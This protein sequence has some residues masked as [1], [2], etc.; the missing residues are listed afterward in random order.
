MPWYSLHASGYSPFFPANRRPSSDLHSAASST[1]FDLHELPKYSGHKRTLQT[2]YAFAC[3]PTYHW[4]RQHV[5]YAL[6]D[7]WDVLQQRPPAYNVVKFEAKRKSAPNSRAVAGGYQKIPVT[8]SPAPT[9]F[10]SSFVDAY[11]SRFT[12]RKPLLVDSAPPK[13]RIVNSEGDVGD[14]TLMDDIL[15]VADILNKLLQARGHTDLQVVVQHQTG[16]SD[17]LAGFRLWITLWSWYARV[18]HCGRLIVTDHL[19]AVA[20]RLNSDTVNPHTLA[21]VSLAFQAIDA[22]S[23]RAPS[24]FDANKP[25]FRHALCM[26]AIEALCGMGV[27]NSQG[28]AQK[29]AEEGLLI[30]NWHATVDNVYERDVRRYEQ[31]RG[32]EKG[33][34]LPKKP[35]GYDGR[36]RRRV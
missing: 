1:L 18:F 22:Q 34:P 31:E 16:S 15:P 8:R 4:Q 29:V 11:K 19:S 32:A 24:T 23:G 10:D 2:T 27:L 14:V 35:M 33:W 5:R 30:R 36:L 7:A 13:I 26:L 17:F 3:S 25:T 28:L 9:F 12:S 20:L 6:N 21:E